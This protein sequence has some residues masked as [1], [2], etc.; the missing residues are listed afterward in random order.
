[1]VLP[2]EH[3][4][5][6]I[7][8]NLAQDIVSELAR[9]EKEESKAPYVRYETGTSLV[10]VRKQDGTEKRITAFDLRSSCGCALCVDEFSGKKVLE[11]KTI[12]KD[13]FPYKIEPKGIMPSQ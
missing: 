12:Q 11:P 2:S 13:V 10:I 5:T 9:L 1:M 7:Y 4:I 3:T 8:N 6:K